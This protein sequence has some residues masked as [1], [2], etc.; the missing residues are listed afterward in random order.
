[1]IEMNLNQPQKKEV[2]GGAN[3]WINVKTNFSKSFPRL[4][5]CGW[6][7]WEYQIIIVEH[8]FINPI[9]SHTNKI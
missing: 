2:G 6:Q 4:G 5:C 1:M 9:H 7:V 8:A 3:K